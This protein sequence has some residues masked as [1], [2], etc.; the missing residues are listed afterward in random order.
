MTQFIVAFA[1][2]IA[3]VLGASPAQAEPI[4]IAL[5]STIGV[6]LAAGTFTTAAITFALGTAVSLGLSYLGR[7]LL[8]HMNMVV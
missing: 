4:T 3:L 6:S 7:A 2:L 1:L 5:F 8:T